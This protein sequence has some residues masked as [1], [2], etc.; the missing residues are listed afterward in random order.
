MIRHIIKCWSPYFDDV[1]AGKKKFE[2]RLNDRNY[3]EGDSIVMRHYDP[4]AKVYSG[5]EWIGTIG[6]VLRGAP[7]CNPAFSEYCIF[8]LIPEAT[9]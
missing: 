9:P 7:C 8:E 5:R 6:Y 1:V 2:A 3:Q 4:Q